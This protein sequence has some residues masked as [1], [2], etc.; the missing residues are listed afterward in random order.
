MREKIIATITLTSIFTLFLYYKVNSNDSN[1]VVSEVSI[2][3]ESDIVNSDII[4]YNSDVDIVE[5][6]N[7]IIIDSDSCSL[8]KTET[9]SFSFSEAFKY[10]RGCLGK[11]EVF[12]W[13]SNSYKTLLASEM[14]VDSNDDTKNMIVE[15][16]QK[17]DRN[18]LNL[19]NQMIGQ[20][21]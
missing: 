12:S 20:N 15:K 11:D 3:S 18:H 17:V 9:D 10:Y 13:N 6:S 1:I 8:S 19:L 21:K 16:D 14:I 5:E 4:D 2:L 7:E